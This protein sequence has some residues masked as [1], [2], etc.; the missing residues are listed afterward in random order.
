[1]LWFMKN[2]AFTIN[3][4]INIDKW[5]HRTKGEL[6]QFPCQY[7]YSEKCILLMNNIED[8]GKGVVLTTLSKGHTLSRGRC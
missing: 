4:F 8:K 1:M 6:Y 5:L 3:R 2:R 7:D